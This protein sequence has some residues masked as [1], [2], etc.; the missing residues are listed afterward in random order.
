MRGRTLRRRVAAAATLAVALAGGGTVGVAQAHD[1]W[2]RVLPP[3]DRGQLVLAL[4][5]GNQ[6]PDYDTPVLA[7][8]VQGSGCLGRGVR[9]T[10]LRPGAETLW[11]TLAEALKGPP[12]LVLRTGRPVSAAV[13]VRCWAQLVPIDIDLDDATVEVYLAE[14]GATPALRQ[15]WAALRAQGVRWRERYVKHARIEIDGDGVTEVVPEAIDGLGL[16]VLTETTARPLR[17]GQRLRWQLRRDG[18]PLPGLP[19]ELRSAS[20]GHSLWLTSDAEGRVEAIL[21]GPGRW[22]LRG[23]D[24]R[25]DAADPQRWDSRFVTLAFEVQAA[26]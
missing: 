8:Q 20:G 4:G 12:W 13:A 11:S 21:P 22:L 26:R 16:D 9:E 15:R 17:A 25:P 14:I 18:R 23:T 10:P 3:T 5:T 19:V 6:Y 7:A 2:F 1:S 24:V